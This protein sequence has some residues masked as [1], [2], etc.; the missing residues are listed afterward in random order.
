M[1]LAID[2]YCFHRY[3]GEHY[4]GLETD[5][6]RRITVI[7]FLDQVQALGATGVSLESCFVPFEDPQARRQLRAELDRRELARVWAWGHPN[8]LGSGTDAA[9]A[10]DLRRHIGI[11]AELG[12]S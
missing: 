2:S 5:P 11:A 4:D 8:G 12:A 1:Q 3:F 10:E 9:A 7:D 6:G